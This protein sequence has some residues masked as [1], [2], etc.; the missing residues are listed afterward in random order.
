MMRL[1]ISLLPSS[2]SGEVTVAVPLLP[3]LLDGG[4]FFSSWRHGRKIP[5]PD[6]RHHEH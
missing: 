5:D 6:P 1:V 2:S 4:G 3:T